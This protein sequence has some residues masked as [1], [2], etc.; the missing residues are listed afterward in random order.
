MLS[1][2]SIEKEPG[3][4]IDS[5]SLSRWLGGE[6]SRGSK[7]AVAA[8]DRS[9]RSLD[10]IDK[11]RGHGAA[12]CLKWT[13]EAKARGA[14]GRD[15]GQL[16]IIR[17]ISK[18]SPSGQSHDRPKLRQ[19]FAYL[20]IIDFESTCWKDGRK[21]YS[22][23][24]IEFPAV[25][26]NTSNGEIE[27]E[28]HMYVQPQEHPILSEFC[29]ELTGITQNQVDEGVPLHICLSQFSKWIQKIQK[30]KNV[31]FT[32]SHSSCA[33]PEGQLCAFVTWSDWDLGV[34]LL[35][36]CKRKQ[37]RKPDI[38]NSWID[39]RA[40]YKL[41]YS[42]KPQGLNGALQDVGII[43]EGREHSGL[44]DSRNTARLAWRM[45]RDGCV[46]KIT[47][48]LHKAPPAKGS[49]ASFFSAKPPDASPLGR[50]DGAKTSV[51]GES[52]NGDV[53]MEVKNNKE[54]QEQEFTPVRLHGDTQILSR[55]CKKTDVCTRIQSCFSPP[56][57]QLDSPLGC[58]RPS[59]P[60]RFSIQGRL[61]NEHLISSSSAQNPGLVLVSTTLS[62][63][64]ISDIDISTTSDCL[65]MLADWEDVALMPASEGD[66]NS[67]SL[68]VKDDPSG[69][70]SFMVGERMDMNELNVMGLGTGDV[71]EDTL[72]MEPSKAVIYKS[73]NTTIYNAGT[74]PTKSSNT[75]VFKLP[76]AKANTSSVD[77]KG[78]PFD[79]CSSEMHKRK[80]SSPKSVPPAKKPAFVVYKDKGTS[81]NTSLPFR[82]GS[83]ILNSS[84]NFNQSLKATET[85][86]VT[87]PLCKCGRRS[88]RLNVS[89]GGPNHGKTF[90]SCPVGKQ[91][92]NRKGCDFFKWEHVFLKEKL[93]PPVSR[94]VGLPT[95]GTRLNSSGNPQRKCLSLRPSMRT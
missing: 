89:K 29:T 39:L 1:K 20:I 85:G 63:V 47:K 45:I 28:F 81:S 33:A 11:R 9:S 50:E 70:G 53:A 61:D 54:N 42:R 58:F 35:Y 56:T 44:D 4:V 68:Q 31:I 65:A 80:P 23:E 13:P 37:L 72:N 77:V 60:S 67:A 21:C 30:E 41:F 57:G 83:G 87:P 51:L 18:T 86:R 15:L 59:Y 24:I 90:F 34:C 93:S 95:L 75:S 66:Q 84:V 7:A 38:L 26:L 82:S 10:G 48:S 12:G 94:I 88:R 6:N 49:V 43:F 69:K 52:R 8:A 62:S 36:E 32:S 25:L 40:T 76:A 16:G 27:S 71:A 73:P 17:T 46:M 92:G 55:N 78:F 64:N 19:L 91:E 5:F 79:K 74:A 22:Q 3:S 2:P 14:E